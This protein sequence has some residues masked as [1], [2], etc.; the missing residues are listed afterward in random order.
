MIYRLISASNVIANVQDTFNIDDSD[1][2]GRASNWISK[3]LTDLGV[4]SELTVIHHE[5]K[6]TD[7]RVELP[8]DIKSL[9]AIEIDGMRVYRSNQLRDSRND[10]L[11]YPYNTISYTVQGDNYIQ[12]ET[13]NE[14]FKDVDVIVHF[15]SLPIEVFKPY[16][17][18]LPLVP[19]LDT[20]Q[21]ALALYIMIKLLGRGYRH[22]VFSL[23]KQSPATNPYIQY[24]GI[25]GKD[26]IRKKA[27]LKIKGMDK[28]AR[29]RVSVSTRSFNHP[30]RHATKDFNNK[31]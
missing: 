5:T 27:R 7:Y 22:N 10:D 4:I 11:N 24:Y 8:C 28:D 12:L 20:V 19:D 3:G 31:L 1:W 25:T 29:E 15:K 9:E 30:D 21:D 18:Y 2:I 17:V 14:Y 23:D 16:D 13:E 6:A 26:G